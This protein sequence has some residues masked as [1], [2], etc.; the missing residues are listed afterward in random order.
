[1]RGHGTL[2][3][4]VPAP[5]RGEVPVRRVGVGLGGPRYGP[6]A[7]AAG[8][9]SVDRGRAGL[10]RAARRAR[11]G[12]RVGPRPRE[13]G[14]GGWG[15]GAGHRTINCTKEVLDESGL[16]DA[17]ANAGERR[18]S[19]S[20]TN[21]ASGSDRATRRR[22]RPPRVFAAGKTWM[23]PVAGSGGGLRSRR[24]GHPAARLAALTGGRSAALRPRPA[25]ARRQLALPSGPRNGRPASGSGGGARGDVGRVPP[26]RCAG[27]PHPGTT[28]VCADDPPG[29]WPGRDLRWAGSRP[30]DPRVAVRGWWWRWLVGDSPGDR[31]SGGSFRG[32]RGAVCS[33]GSGGG[34]HVRGLRRWLRCRQVRRFGGG[35]GRGGGGNSLEGRA[36]RPGAGT[37]EKP[38][39]AAPSRVT[40]SAG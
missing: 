20:R 40:D 30:V 21:M 25:P 10:H 29:L 37:A 6:G 8:D 17:V 7:P 24:G 4:V 1:M 15:S 31:S 11:T 27:W 14:P 22:R 23:A 39:P 32:T 3:S 26:R 35:V 18:E 16:K 33:G 28:T 13:G 2:S 9:G 36:A 12:R 19:A 34:G 38:V 5:T